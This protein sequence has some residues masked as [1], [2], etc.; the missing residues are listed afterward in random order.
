MSVMSRQ[1]QRVMLGA[2]VGAFLSF[3]LPALSQ[4]AAAEATESIQLPV[5]ELRS[6]VEVFGRIKHDYVDS[7]GDKQL[8]K[9]AISGMLAGLDPHSGFLDREEFRQMQVVT[10]GEFGGLGIEVALEGGYVKVVSPIDD[11]PAARAG[12]RAGDLIIKLDDVSVRSMTLDD[13]LKRIR[14][15]PDTTITLTITRKGEEKPLVVTLTRA[16]IKVQSVKSTL[17]EPGYAYFRIS[18][19]QGPTGREL[20]KAIENAYAQNGGRMQG[21]VLDLRN[22]PGGLLDAA[23]AVSAAF[24]PHDALVVS[25]RGRVPESNTRLTASPHYYLPEGGADFLSRLPAAVKDT[26]MVVLVNAG[27][28]SASEIVAGALQDY[29]RAVVMGTPTFG[30]A[31]VQT[32]LPLGDGTAIKLTTARYYTP[33]GRSLQTTGV[34]PDIALDDGARAEAKQILREGDL[35]GHLAGETK[36]AAA[37]VARREFDF[38][39]AARPQTT[40]AKDLLPV[41]GAVVAKDDY[42][43]AQAVAFLK[44]RE[45]VQT[46][47]K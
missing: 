41:P 18:Q 33:S 46:S 47:A 7:V 10:R 12:I 31:S 35:N 23:V 42:E 39:P 14:G 24:L 27:S 13:A 38:K 16:V 20:A 1:L 29:Q 5:D 6:F 15:K 2:V 17:L 36:T 40:D 26:P 37:P 4:P 22:D 3:N 19:F 28:A 32:I 44:S 45:R 34:T 21:L 9:Q 25:T 43:L 11:S 8:L 30:K